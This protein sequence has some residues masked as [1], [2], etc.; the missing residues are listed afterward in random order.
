MGA[1]AK[2]VK[3]I[4][5]AAYGNWGFP[6]IHIEVMGGERKNWAII[7]VEKNVSE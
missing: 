2:M 3:K 5:Y 7:P 4:N 6:K 1:G